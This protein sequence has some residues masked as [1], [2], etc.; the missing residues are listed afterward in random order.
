M[1]LRSQ[2]GWLLGAAVLVYADSLLNS[3]TMDDE[4][5]I[6]RNPQVTQ[7]SAWLLF[8]PNTVSNVY[9]PVTFFTFAMNWIAARYQPF[10]YHAI[11]LLLHLA[12]V[13]LLFFVLRE[14][15]EGSA[16][17]E[18]VCFAAALLFAV[19][20]IHTE[21]VSSVVGRSELLAAGFLLAAWL[22]H[23]QDRYILSLFCVVLALLSKESAIGLLPLAVAG[24]YAKG[25]L[26]SWTRYAAIAVV[27][28]LYVGALWK[29][30]GGHLGAAA[31]SV[32]DNPLTLLPAS[33]RVLNAVRIAWKYVAL[34]LFPVTLSCDY[35]YN[36]IL[37]YAD[38]R[39]LL[40]P[41]IAA[42]AVVL[43]WIWAIWKKKSGYIVAGAVYFAGFAAT[44]N[45]LTRT[46]TIFGE[47]LAYLPSAGFCLL[48]AL[49]W[50]WL[51]D[52]HR[53]AAIAVLALVVAALGIRAAARNR[54]WRDNTALYTQAGD[55][56]PNSAK[57]R[58]FR[59]IVYLG[60]GQFDR[61][62][63]DLQAALNIYPEF[64]DAVEAM[65]LLEAR[66]GNPKEA[67]NWMQKAVDMSDHRDIDY[68][69]RTVNLAALD[70]Q[71]GRLDDA[72]KLLNHDIAESPNYSRSWSNRAVVRLKLGQIAEARED[73][74]TALALDPSNLQARSILEGPNSSPLP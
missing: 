32:L 39:H 70:I 13:L 4:L 49:A 10:G 8:H 15:L 22:F 20:P 19:H 63:S 5:Y 43:A 36:Q 68:D 3:F 48:A 28:F 73:A 64:P 58:T 34:L 50:Q 62:R 9:R 11:N 44:S 1:R 47:R 53:N 55:A 51:A 74:R 2:I 29:I 30:Q 67:L 41:A 52:R 21:A 12:V 38:F 66:T 45:I 56:V 42:M 35:S 57:M 37:L 65:G 60:A 46:G 18:P 72:M 14:I 61:S 40:V 17:Y 27:S 7:H 23:L 25:Q 31:V 69:Y 59:G 24:D 6:L 16:H 33:L 71:I 26:K 54:D